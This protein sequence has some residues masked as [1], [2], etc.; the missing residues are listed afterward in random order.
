MW[1]PHEGLGNK[2]PAYSE[3]QLCL[4][5]LLFPGH[6]RMETSWEGEV[7]GPAACQKYH[8]N[9]I[10]MAPEATHS[11]WGPH[12]WA[13]PLGFPSWRTAPLE[14]AY[15]HKLMLV[16]LIDINGLPFTAEHRRRAR[17]H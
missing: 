16:L 15:S 12:P 6:V 11:Q 10:L 5:I 7:A 13:S 2:A 3:M 4:E 9:T 17:P 8:H 1:G 14:S